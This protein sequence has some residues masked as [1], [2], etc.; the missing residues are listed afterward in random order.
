MLRHG[1]MNSTLAIK[2]I[3][4]SIQGEGMLSG[5]RQIFVR[6]TDCNLECT[7]CDTN[8]TRS[9]VCH[10]ETYPGSS[11]L[12]D[13]DQQFTI[14]QLS[15]VVADWKRQL[16]HTHHSI[17][18]TGGEPLL[19][20]DILVEWLPELRKLFPV[21]LETNGTMPQ[22]LATIVDLLDFI[23]MDMKLPSTSGC[24]ENLWELHHLF[25][26]V[27]QRTNVSVKVVVGDETSE[28]EI[29][30]VCD[31]ISDINS[32][33]PLFL[34]PVTLVDGTVAISRSHLFHLQ[35]LASLRLPYVRVV[36]QM[37]KLLGVM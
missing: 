16:P 35:E 11:T 21:H 14:Q 1:T 3:F 32:N 22:A 37:H 18:L 8:H 13:R 2:E 36:P 34:Q 15:N 33:V 17:S 19:Y 25:L 28:N 9:G 7:Y 26:N 30:M 12:L 29:A 6:L 4:S 27:A 23:S 20:S 31:S 10:V 5:C 24:T